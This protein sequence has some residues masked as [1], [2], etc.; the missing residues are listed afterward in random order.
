MIDETLVGSPIIINPE[1]VG[2]KE[3]LLDDFIKV[4]I[5]K[6]KLDTTFLN[7]IYLNHPERVTLGE[8]TKEEPPA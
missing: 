4:L 2:D 6:Y 1:T 7:K 5:E 8:A 3:I